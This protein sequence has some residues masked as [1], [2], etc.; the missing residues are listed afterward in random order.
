MISSACERAIAD[1]IHYG[2]ALL[3]FISAN[4][5]GITG[6]HQSGFYLPKVVATHF[7][8]Q[9]PQK[10]VNHD[11]LVTVT[12]PDG[13]ITESVVKWYGKETRSEY[14][15]TRFG[16][17]FQWR[18]PERLGD[19]LVLIPQ[20][21]E[22]IIAHVLS[23][24]EDIEELQ[25]V[26]GVEVVE[27]WTFYEH[28]QYQIASEDACLDQRFR[29]FA[30]SVTV[31]SEVRVFSETT[32]TAIFDC[33][34]G[35]GSVTPDAQLIRLIREEYTLY[36]MIERKVFQP[37]VQ[38]VFA[39]IDE[40]LQAALSILQARKSRAGRSLEN[41]VEYLLRR[42]NIPFEMRQVVENTR[43]DIV[44]PGKAQYDDPAYPADRLAMIGVKM[45]CKDRW[46]QVTREAP[47]IKNKHILTLQEGIS[48]KQLDEMRRADITLIVPEPLHRQ[49]PPD[50]RDMV[51]SLQQFIS[52]M[53]SVYPA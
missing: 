14:R 4:D 37:Q 18:T 2:K 11:H 38:R 28:G 26:L 23:N 19:L 13:Q 45:T 8:P 16:R 29:A 12:W 1:A 49:Y 41:H 39:T 17:G 46:R 40:F 35:F 51:L 25:A 42:S 44:I 53:Q 24:D 21:R 33:V 30:A 36:R 10:E 7:T 22:R 27:S 43:P 6:G 34:R 50:R 31:F 32:R 52:S 48:A 47:R 9:Q 20:S 3:K 15:L 5:V